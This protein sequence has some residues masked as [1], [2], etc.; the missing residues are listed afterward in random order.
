[1]TA[2]CPHWNPTDGNCKECREM[3]PVKKVTK[4][5]II[6]TIIY[7]MNQSEMEE[8]LEAC[9]KKAMMLNI[10]IGTFITIIGGI[11]ILMA[12]K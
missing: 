9:E 7:S 6:T 2:T 8:K 10:A 12:L 11:I 1:M 5:L 4:A 3:L